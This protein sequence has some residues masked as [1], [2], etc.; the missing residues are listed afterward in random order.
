M[1][2]KYISPFLLASL[3]V[4]PSC[5]QKSNSPNPD[6][7][8]RAPIE[9]VEGTIASTPL[10]TRPNQ[11]EGSP[12]FETI[13]ISHSGV[14]YGLHWDNPESRIKEFLFLNP[15]GGICTGDFDGDKLPD[16]YITSPSGGNRLYKNLGDFKFEDVTQSSGV[17]DETFW[18]TGA[19]FV[20]IDND[21]D[22]DLYAC[23]YQCPNK[24][25]LNDG[26][27]KFS[28]QAGALGLDYKGGSMMMSF[29]DIDNDGDLDGYL[30]TTAVTP[31]AGTKFKVKFV[32]RESDGVEVPVVLPELREY[33]EILY[34]PGDK[35]RRVE[36][37]QYDHLFRNDNG[38]FV[39]VSK[40]AGID[41]AF[42][43]LS[44]TWFDYDSDG[45]PD[46]Y[47]SNDY[48]GPDML[49]R[50]RGDG[51]FENVIQETV[52]H[53]PWFS[54]G[55]DVGDFNND[56]LLDLFASD[57]SATSHYREKVMM[58]NMDDSA[59][60]LDWSKPRQ[61]MRNSVY[62]NSG[63][64]RFQEASFL[65][66]LSS[67]D[68]TW[69]PRIEDF[70][71]D[72]HTD[73]FVTNGVM[74]D[75]MNSDL[76]EFAN[77]NLEPGSA[78]YNIFWL[79]KPMRKERNLA[80][81][82]LGDLKFKSKGQDWGLERNGVS[83]GAATADFDGDGDVDL[84][85][86]N[87]DT[88]VSIYRNNSSTNHRIAVTLEGV[89]S[90]RKGLGATILVKTKAGTQTRTVTLSRGWLSASDTTAMFGLGAAQKVERLEIHWPG[91]TRQIFNKLDANHSYTITEPVGQPAPPEDPQTT[92]LFLRSDHLAS[93]IHQEA[94]FDD[95]KIQPLL[96]NKLSQNGPGIAWG[97]I[98]GDG[99]HDFFLGG[100][101]SQSGQLF[102]NIGEGG[103]KK[104]TTEVLEADKN[105]EDM[106]ALFFDSDNDG[107]LD[108][109]V[110][111]GSA[112]APPGDSTYRDQLY[113]NHGKG[114]FSKSPGDTL[115]QLSISSGPVACADIDRDGDLDLFV[116]GRLVPGQYPTGPP[117][118]I[119]INNRGKFSAT[120]VP[121]LGMVTGAVFSDADDD[122]WIDLL[123]TTEW[124]PVRFLK[125]ENGKL[126]EKTDQAGLATRTGWW[127]GIA[128][129]D[130]D[131]DGD[132]DFLVTNFGLNT[133]YKAS[134]EK[135]ALAYFGDVDGSGRPHL[136]EAKLSDGK[137]L[138][139][140]GFSCSK[141]AMPSLQA[142]VGTFHNFASSAL[143]ELYSDSRLENALKFEAN[144]LE[145]G[146]LIN[147]GK[148]RFSWRPLPRFA[149]ISPAFGAILQDIDGDGDLDAALA[150]N[151]YGPQRE[152]GRMDGGLGLILEND[153][154]GNFHPMGARESG[155]VI[156]EDAKSLS[157]A[158]LNQDQRPD[159]IFGMNNGPVVTYL[160]QSQNDVLAVTLP[161]AAVGAK[162]TINSNS[163]SL[164]GGG[165]YLS[166]ST[167]V[168]VFQA[169]KEDT[170]AVIRWPDGSTKEVPLATGTR[171]LVVNH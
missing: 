64:G 47:V 118:Q 143:N 110:A 46:L 45:D 27:G 50:N 88:P 78:E 147:N 141:S 168:L 171:K 157:L 10:P 161:A 38:K 144:T 139:R 112:E 105:S 148:G 156:P 85:V 67:T 119:L 9:P 169:P 123:L 120:L 97:D 8:K 44:A 91:G 164:H 7:N 126:V 131:S 128:G 14:D 5:E 77:K 100:A 89:A 117:S 133:K 82:N 159:L 158:D 79:E 55:S 17:A 152:T 63:A 40:S 154:S 28:D 155:I 153:G 11:T 150:Q 167:P 34:L 13:N 135:P 4:L 109:Y 56:G 57:M 140:R 103:F 76:T 146:I 69:T 42:F 61:Y 48:T 36:A 129:G 83:F 95:F 160:N 170:T 137:L 70:D 106:G 53:T 26:S 107:D 99:D 16:L 134:D 101:K 166:Q 33:W 121:N 125:N 108:L 66:G 124:G 32:P 73:V 43:T 114:R 60:F 136:I 22:L 31:P 113:L 29:A 132:I 96:P 122:G 30:S 93:A 162:V 6:A 49:Y 72:G 138:P 80:F 74:R 75:N 165:S 25:Y 84:V 19:S 39:D 86:N 54:M 104:V 65:A 90:N 145:S 37:A 130:L 115:P 68:W 23:G 20:D 151:F 111:H 98:D 35:V 18:G 62:V 59:W 94:P 71:Q 21:G 2:F 3:V 149:Q 163:R 58:G 142:K 102:E 12:L 127:N 116:G 15:A 87:A 92:P 51:T 81:Q 24:L 52:P 41:G 1:V